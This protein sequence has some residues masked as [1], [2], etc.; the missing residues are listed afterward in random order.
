MARLNVNPTLVDPDR[1]YQKLLAMH[2]GLSDAES[3]RRN[4]RL[5]LCLVNHIG[6]PEVVDEA[7]AIALG[8]DKV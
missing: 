1:V 5:I 2:E 6:D 8:K 3:H 7:I 4:A